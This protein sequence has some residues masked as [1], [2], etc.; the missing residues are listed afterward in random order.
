MRLNCSGGN[1]LKAYVDEIDNIK[2]SILIAGEACNIDTLTFYLK[3]KGLKVIWFGNESDNKK[4]EN[5]FS[6]FIKAGFLNVFINN[7][8]VKTKIID[9][10][11]NDDGV[12]A[13]LEKGDENFNLKQYKIEHYDAG[14]NL[15][16]T[17]GA[18]TGKTHVMVNRIM[19]LMHSCPNFKFADVAMITFTNKATDNMR[20]RLIDTLNSKYKLTG[21]TYYLKRVEELSQIT[22]STIHSF[23]KK[24]I[25]TVS[26]MLGYGTNLELTSFIYDKQQ[27]LLDII[28]ERFSSSNK[29]VDSVLGLNVNQIRKLADSYW[30]KIENCGISE[31]ELANMDWG[32][33]TESTSSDEYIDPECIQNTLIDIFNQVNTRYNELKFKKN[34]IG[35]SDIIHELSRVIKNQEITDYLNQS[36]KF[37][38]CDEFQ[39][40]DNVQIF[41]IVILSKLFGAK[42]FVVGDIKQSIYRFRGATDSAFDEIRDSL[43]DNGLSTPTTIELEK[44][45]RTSYS[46]MDAIRPKF[47]LWHNKNL[48]KDKGDLK[49]M[50]TFD[51]SFEVIDYKKMYKGTAD[52]KYADLQKAFIAKVNELRLSETEDKTNKKSKTMVLTRTNKQLLHIKRWCE[53]NQIVCHIKERGAFYKS[54]AVKDFCS[55]IEALLYFNEP[56]YLYNLICSSY[57]NAE[58]DINDHFKNDYNKERLVQEFYK[59]IGKEKISKYKNELLKKPAI[60]VINDIINEADPKTTYYSMR[61]KKLLKSGFTKDDAP[62]QALID[63]SLY[64]ANLDKLLEMIMENFSSDFATLYDICSFLRLKILTDNNEEE[65]DIDISNDTFFIEGMTVHSSKGLEFDNVL[66]P[67]TDDKIIQDYRSE[68]LISKSKKMIGWKYVSYNN[69][70]KSEFSNDNYLKLLKE[71]KSEVIQEETRLLYVAMTRA[72]KGLFCFCE[73]S[74]RKTDEIICWGD[75]LRMGD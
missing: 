40:S 73:K 5:D 47:L 63:M 15:I 27:I 28:D 42:L 16:I 10:I 61:I 38:F 49:A 50:R 35:M 32:K 74:K 17:A 65:A 6:D 72:V 22:L 44:N 29:R 56:V 31:N 30:K 69:G 25:V 43:K 39:D 21:N 24:V 70:E 68:I 54:D 53:S 26:P 19:F 71:E 58:F 3:D 11:T 14:S 45:Y 7:N 8:N 1:I 67:F 33:V 36:Y 62:K 55:M 13:Q 12:L 66:I 60:A 37:I 64:S 57:C 52:E 75:L 23:F 51:G 41:T 34:A 48:L 20:K 4:L 59:I 18:G 46:V 2:Y 9:G